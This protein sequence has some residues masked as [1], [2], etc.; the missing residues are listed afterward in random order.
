MSRT[1]RVLLLAG[2]KKLQNLVAFTT[3]VAEE[4]RIHRREPGCSRVTVQKPRNNPAGLLRA[5]NRE[6]EIILFLFSSLWNRTFRQRNR[7]KLECPERRRKF[8]AVIVGF[9]EF[10]NNL[11]S[12]RLINENRRYKRDRLL[13]KS[14]RC[15]NRD[16]RIDVVE[17]GSLDEEDDGKR[18]KE[19][20]RGRSNGG[21][22]EE[23]KRTRRSSISEARLCVNVWLAFGRQP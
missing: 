4:V 15:S 19:E 12:F 3:D 7:A 6:Q 22:R 23:T 1:S 9:R 2:S 13:P 14:E 8:V 10:L 18:G 11:Y 17:S 20:R 5:T 21:W 16:E